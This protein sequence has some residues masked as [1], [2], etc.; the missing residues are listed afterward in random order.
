MACPKARDSVSFNMKFFKATKGPQAVRA[1]AS[2][3]TAA[4]G[5]QGGWRSPKQKGKS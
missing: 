1:V 4:E 2:A 3:G 5:A